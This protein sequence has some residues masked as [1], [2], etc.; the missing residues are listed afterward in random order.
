MLMT[1]VTKTLDRLTVGCYLFIIVYY[2]YLCYSCKWRR[3]VHLD[4]RTTV[5]RVTSQRTGPKRNREIEKR[6][7]QRLP[8]V[9]ATTLQ[10][11]PGRAE[12]DCDVINKSPRTL[13]EAVRRPRRVAITAR[14]LG[15]PLIRVELRCR[16]SAAGRT[17]QAHKGAA[18][19]RIPP[20]TVTPPPLLAS[21]LLLYHRQGGPFR[22]I[23]IAIRTQ[24]RGT[25]EISRW[26]KC[27][28]GAVDRLMAEVVWVRLTQ[29]ILRMM[30]ITFNQ[31]IR[32]VQN[33][34]YKWFQVRS[35][36]QPPVEYF[37]RCYISV[38]KQRFFFNVRN[39]MTI[40]VDNYGSLTEYILIICSVRPVSKLGGREF[41][42]PALY[43]EDCSFKSSLRSSC[44]YLQKGDLSWILSTS[45]LKLLQFTLVLWNMA[46]HKSFIHSFIH[47]FNSIIWCKLL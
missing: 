30:Q 42:S 36:V 32:T 47:S 2:W 22:L 37:P 12:T 45:E 23:L 28:S 29:S 38:F 26:M 15:T 9:N 8:A 17:Q 24:S 40:V 44:Y 4:L 35:T 19:T 31:S 27:S 10:T 21:I 11:L 18:E 3:P 25:T 46:L 43:S 14:T 34:I 6:P 33:D 16:P 13:T 41:K 7:P 20:C 1:N 5:Q 39:L